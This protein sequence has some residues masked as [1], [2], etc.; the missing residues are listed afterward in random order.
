MLIFVVGAATV[1]AILF[2]ERLLTRAEAREK[3]SDPNEEPLT[4]EHSRAV[5]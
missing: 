1:V 4:D 3:E 5:G 2:R